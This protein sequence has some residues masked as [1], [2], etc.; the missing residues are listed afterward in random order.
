M[1]LGRKIV[2]HYRWRPDT[3][4]L[5]SLLLVHV[6]DVSSMQCRCWRIIDSSPLSLSL[7]SVSDH[8]VAGQDGKSSMFP[9]LET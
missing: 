5:K 4:D 3:L 6:Q 9:C 7:A 8:L 2:K 1:V